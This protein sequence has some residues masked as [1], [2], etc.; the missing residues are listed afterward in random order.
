MS[1]GEIKEKKGENA[2]RARAI[3]ALRLSRNVRIFSLFVH[4]KRLTCFAE[5]RAVAAGLFSR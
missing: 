4:I 5:G 1:A 2:M 3:L